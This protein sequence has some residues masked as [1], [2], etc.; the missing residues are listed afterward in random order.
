MV[1]AIS[2]VLPSAGDHCARYAR[3]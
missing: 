1:D 2:K 3:E